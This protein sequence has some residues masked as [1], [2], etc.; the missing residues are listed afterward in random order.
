MA[1]QGSITAYD[2]ARKAIMIADALIDEL[3]KE[4]K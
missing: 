4:K 2:H 1:L 3:N